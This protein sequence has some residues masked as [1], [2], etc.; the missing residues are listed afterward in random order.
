[1]EGLEASGELLVPVRNQTRLVILEA[2]MR[3][4]F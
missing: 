2:E 3:I 4:R 1:M